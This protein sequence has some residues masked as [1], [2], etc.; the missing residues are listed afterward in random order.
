M[1]GR[2]IFVCGGQID[3]QV[4]NHAEI[5]SDEVNQWEPIAATMAEPRMGLTMVTMDSIIY[6]MGKCL[7]W[8][9]S[10]ELG[11]GVHGGGVVWSKGNGEGVMWSKG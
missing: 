9:C 3:G 10:V 5:Y 4:V 8:R 7:W 6:V 2:E 11:E 1:V